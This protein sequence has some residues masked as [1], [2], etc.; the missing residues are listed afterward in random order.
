MRDKI[1]FKKDI[2]FKNNIAEISSI[3]LE[4][5][6]DCLENTIDGNFILEGS[7]RTYDISVSKEEFYY[8]LPFKYEFK[9]NIEPNSALVNV[10]DFTYTIDKDTL[11]INIEYETLADKQEVMLFED[12]TEFERFIKEKEIPIEEITDETKEK[13]IEVNPLEEVKEMPVITIKEEPLIEELEVEETRGISELEPEIIN[14]IEPPKVDVLEEESCMNNT[15]IDD[16]SNRED[17]YITYHIHICDDTDTIDSIANQYKISTEIIKNYNA[18]DNI[19][20]GM[21]I[22]IPAT[23]E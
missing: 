19:T 9:E 22:I 16:I 6:Y 12:K 3:S 15:I 1:N 17:T 8:R 18:I 20:T 7:Y 23:D 5:D 10:K 4:C 13:N 14:D 21:K 2:Q 11:C